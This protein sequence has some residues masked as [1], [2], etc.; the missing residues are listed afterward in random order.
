MSRLTGIAPAAALAALAATSTPA[1]AAS[2]ANDSFRVGSDYD[3]HY[4]GFGQAAQLKRDIARLDARVD[5]ALSHRQISH[6]EAFVLRRDVHEL[7]QL[8]NRF[9]RGGMTRWEARTLESRL[10]QANRAFVLERRERDRFRG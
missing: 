2:R 4:A 5:R 7:R 6:R 9:T 1:L 8:Y 3:R 10:A